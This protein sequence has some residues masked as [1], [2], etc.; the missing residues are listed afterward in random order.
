MGLGGNINHTNNKYVV[1]C[2]P[3]FRIVTPS[4]QAKPICYPIIITD[5]REMCL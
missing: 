4:A 3:D 1:D 2:I 5:R